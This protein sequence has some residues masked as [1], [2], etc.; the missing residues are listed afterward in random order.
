VCFWR[1]SL[2]I[3]NRLLVRAL[4]L[5]SCEI[6]LLLRILGSSSA[7]SK[8]RSISRL[9]H[10]C[11]LDTKLLTQTLTLITQ[12]INSFPFFG[13]KVFIMFSTVIPFLTTIICLSD[14]YSIHHHCRLLSWKRENGNTGPCISNL[15]SCHPQTEQRRISIHYV[16]RI[17][18][19]LRCLAGKCVK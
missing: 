17:S 4:L 8:S 16:S 6:A 19:D 5:L 7:I 2:Y 15:V 13:A 10:D 12:S 3:C 9:N 1:L 11:F 18:I 14:D